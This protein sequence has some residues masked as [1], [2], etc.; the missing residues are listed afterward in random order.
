MEKAIL[1]SLISSETSEIIQNLPML[2]GRNLAVFVDSGG[3]SGN[4]FTGTLIEVQPLCIKLITSFPKASC[5]H[6]NRKICRSSV[7]TCTV[8]FTNHITAITYSIL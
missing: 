8:I 6:C 7:G 2:I 5:K 4:S 3:V 1:N